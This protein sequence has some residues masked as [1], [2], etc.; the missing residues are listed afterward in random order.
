MGM[1]RRLKEYNPRIRIVGVEP[2]LGHKIQGLKN[3]KEAYQPEI[4]DKGLL[5]KKVN[6]D[7]EEAFE[8]TRRLARE[9]GI[10]VGMSS[11][12]AMAIAAKEAGAAYRR[13]DC[14]DLSGFRRTLSQ[15]VALCGSRKNRDESIQHP[16]AAEKSLFNPWFRVRFRCIPAAPRPMTECT[17][18]NAGGLCFRICSAGIWVSGGLM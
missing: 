9:E 8:M 15:H 6:I 16:H 13:R 5:D 18:A 2:Y 14:G 17:S 7:D 3:M 10:F 12:A 4:Y 11:G 1:S